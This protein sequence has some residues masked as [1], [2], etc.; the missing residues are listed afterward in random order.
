MNELKA[1][2][3]RIKFII[4]K[5]FLA[6][7]NDPKT[8]LTLFLPALLQSLLFGYGASFNLD[9]VP[10][11]VFDQSHSSYSTELLAHLDG[12]GIF[13]R[14]RTLT[15]TSQIADAI[16]SDDALLVV[17]FES[18]FADKIA[19]G[20]S[21][22]VQIIMDGRN[23]TTAGVA[24]NYLSTIISDYNK[25]LQGGTILETQSV[26]RFNPNLI[27]RWMFLPSM[28]VMLSLSQVIMLA[29][30]S[31]AREREQG[32]FDQLLVTPLSPL[33]ILIGKAV[34]PMIIGMIQSSIVLLISVFWFDVPLSGSLFLIYLTLFIF[35]LSCVGIGLGISAISLNMQQVMVYCFV[36]LLPMNLL[37]GMTAPV[38]NMPEVLQYCTYV[39]P[40]RFAIEN[41]RRIYLEGA[42]FADIGLNFI[43]MILVAAVTLPAAAWLFRNK[44]S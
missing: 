5:E 38:R 43:P 6:T 32:T 42:T 29:G 17:T 26:A 2:W 44:L 22:E 23:S 19:S 39:N 13:E 27:T 35:M 40:L 12:T 37:S 25:D 31:V 41:V 15:S 3:R 1:F 20:E 11:A 7:L 28:I 18:Q 16:D 14:T 10:Y 21:A 30:L 24:S 33:E 4:T 36:L 34:P 8:R 9:S